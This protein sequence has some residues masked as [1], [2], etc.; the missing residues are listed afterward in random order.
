MHRSSSPACVT[1]LLCL[2]IIFTKDA[3]IRVHTNT[4]NANTLAQ[5]DLC[6]CACVSCS[7]Y[8]PSFLRFMLVSV[9]KVHL[10]SGCESFVPMIVCVRGLKE[11]LAIFFQ[12]SVFCSF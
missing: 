5:F 9:L 2:N 10:I 8:G 3:R 11:W 12:V 6:G 1:L 7:L 4:R